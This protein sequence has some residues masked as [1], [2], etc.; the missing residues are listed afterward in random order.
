MANRLMARNKRKTVA[1]K[2][3]VMGI[4]EML[5]PTKDKQ[6]P[7]EVITKNKALEKLSGAKSSSKTHYS[8]LKKSIAQMQKCNINLTYSQKEIEELYELLKKKADQNL[9]ILEVSRA[10][11]N[12]LPFE[13]ILKKTNSLV[14][15]VLGPVN[16]Y[17]LGAKKGRRVT[18]EFLVADNLTK[19]SLFCEESMEELWSN[20]IS[21]KTPVQFSGVSDRKSCFLAVPL[22][23][24]SYVIGIL[25]IE[26]EDLGHPFTQEEIE[27]C[28]GIAGP[29]AV[30]I[31]NRALVEKLEKESLRLKTAILSLEVMS[32]NSA[33]LNNGA[34]PLIYAIGQSLIQ[35]TNAKYAMIMTHEDKLVSIHVP[36]PYKEKEKLNSYF[37]ELLI[38]SVA[39]NFSFP[40][41]MRY[42]DVK[43]D[44]YLD[45]LRNSY[46]IEEIVIFPMMIRNE[47]L[48]L[49]I[50][51]FSRYKGDDVCQSILQILGNQTAIILENARLFE[52]TIRLKDKAESH[53]QIACKQK[54]QL[55]Q[56]NQELKNMYNILF[57]TREEQAISHERNRIAGDLHDNVLQILFAIGL[58]FEWCFNEL[59]PQ[60]PVYLKLKY[61]EG[62][63]HKA[64]TEI[65]KVVTEFGSAE[66]SFSLQESI[67]GLVRDLNQAGSV[68]IYLTS[69][70][71]P[72]L[73]GVV[74]NIAFR[75]VQEALMNALRHASASEIKIYLS[76]NDT[77]IL[78]T[79]IDNGIG[80]NDNIMEKIQKE[81]KFGLKNM[82]QRARYI[83]GT[84]KIRRLDSGGTE[85]HAVIPVKGV[86]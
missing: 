54:E 31:E 43:N 11:S 83:D 73:P 59:F 23:S 45:F 10:V 30:A 17:L 85:I 32:D 33:L 40:F 65:R 47:T 53:Y 60:S 42:L 13:Q 48:G 1:P 46:N 69:G 29:V 20:L 28:A 15:Q 2:K 16:C 70:A 26:R 50:L 21:Y 7:N 9:A 63:I 25:I 44:Q 55:E 35:I 18:F 19:N 14:A 64:V 66:K 57:Q 68:R 75:I 74:R 34:E 82:L 8:E 49:I 76:Y 5:R 12:I 58:H 71:I 77:K 41:G 24:R 51:F 37:S 4:M 86:D 38:N 61:V 52:D 56:K 3:Q 62:L 39:N 22:I 78:I 27:L 6:Y 81:N 36:Q 67:E 80:I 72:I 79:V 84:L